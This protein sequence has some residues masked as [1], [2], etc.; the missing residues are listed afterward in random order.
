MKHK[1]LLKLTDEPVN[2]QGKHLQR[3][4]LAKLPRYETYMPRRGAIY[5]A[6]LHFQV[7]RNSATTFVELR[8]S[9]WRAREHV[10]DKV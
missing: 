10:Q 6:V 4:K 1:Y 7:A 5:T 9:Y 8:Q 2:V 3:A